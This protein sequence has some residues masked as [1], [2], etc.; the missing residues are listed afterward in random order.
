VSVN[1]MC[2]NL[3]RKAIRLLLSAFLFCYLM[4]FTCEACGSSQ[5]YNSDR[6]LRQHQLNCQEFLQA[7]NEYNTV[8]DALEK[9]RGKLLRKKQKLKA[10]TASQMVSLTG[11]GVRDSLRFYSILIIH[12]R[13]HQWL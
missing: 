7:D 10:Q 13:M 6:G 1:F 5:N 4:V 9:Y 11:S 3:T 8:E 12:S 2:V